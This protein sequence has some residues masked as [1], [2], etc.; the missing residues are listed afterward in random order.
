M[1]LESHEQYPEI[2]QGWTLIPGLVGL[3]YYAKPC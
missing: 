3:L 2:R 1:E